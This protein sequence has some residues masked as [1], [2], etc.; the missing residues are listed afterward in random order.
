MG[1][2]TSPY[3]GSD[4]NSCSINVADPCQSVLPSLSPPTIPGSGGT[5]AIP[6]PSSY[7]A[8]APAMFFVIIA[9]FSTFFI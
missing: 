5:V 8:I 2:C 7:G 3:L 4:V 9:V 6:T 1:C